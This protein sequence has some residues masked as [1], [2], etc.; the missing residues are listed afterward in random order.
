MLIIFMFKVSVVM[1]IYSGLL[2]NRKEWS[3][4]SKNLNTD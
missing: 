4:T 3:F 2:G 1:M